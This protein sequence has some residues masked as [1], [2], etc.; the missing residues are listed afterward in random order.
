MLN[1]E[2]LSRE[3]QELH[4]GTQ[5]STFAAERSGG[6][7]P[8]EP[9]RDAVGMEH[10]ED[11]AFLPLRPDLSAAPTNCASDALSNYL[12]A[13][14]PRPLFLRLALQSRAGL[15]WFQPTSLMALAPTII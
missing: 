9:W 13:P 10:A 5:A 11:C 3:A 15:H 1:C 4:P 14:T 8:A 2:P 6:S 12:L 7:R